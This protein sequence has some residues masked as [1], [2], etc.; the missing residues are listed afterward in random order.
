MTLPYTFCDCIF[1]F[2][3]QFPFQKCIL[4]WGL[5]VKQH[6]YTKLKKYG[7]ISGKLHNVTK[8][9][10]PQNAWPHNKLNWHPKWPPKSSKY[11]KMHVLNSTHLEL[12]K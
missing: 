11:Y 6:K 3:R 9:G 4:L 1:E 8:M 5:D 7:A 12:K 10:P 2:L